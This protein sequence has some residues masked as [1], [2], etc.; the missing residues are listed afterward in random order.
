MERIKRAI[1]LA[2]GEGKRLRPVTLTTP[3]PLIKVKGRSFI[4]R[5]I[6]DLKKNDIHEIYIVTGYKKECFYEAFKDDPE[7]KIIEN[8]YYL[9]GNNITS[10]YV[11]RDY[12]PE[13]FIIEGDQIIND[14]TIFNPEIEKSGYVA[15]FLDYAPEWAIKVENGR[16][17]D[18]SIEGRENSYRLWGVS[19]WGRHDGKML[20]GFVERQ[21]E[22]L[23]DLSIYWDEIALSPKRAGSSFDLGIREINE[24]DIIE[25]DTFE[26]L[27]S[28]DSSYKDYH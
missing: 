7:I 25:I 16:I 28:L 6:D 22:V 24:G 23:K 14:P 1:I 17:L 18:F 27:V 3:K 19:M 4:H 2:A 20:A 12:L 10:I 9:D 21:V 11:A 15:R 5:I 8:P 26:E 13:S